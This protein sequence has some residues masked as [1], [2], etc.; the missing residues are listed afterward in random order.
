MGNSLN[1]FSWIASLY[2]SLVKIVFGANLRVAQS[3]L[4]EHIPHGNVL[5][6]GGGSGEFLNLLEEARF[7]GSVVYLDSSSAMIR[8]SAQRTVSFPVEFICGLAEEY[9]SGRI[10]N[11]VVTN[12]FLDVYRDD[13]LQR[14]IETISGQTAYGAIWYVT[15]FTNGGQ[16]HHKVLLWMMYRFFNLTGS[17]DARSL[18]DWNSALGASGWELQRQAKT[19]H[20]FITTCVY[21]K[22]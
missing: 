3:Q 10:Y 7:N 4:I 8:L 20:G 19:D 11:A 13:Q 16:P 22:R 15:D 21:R 2:D 9:Q 1:R 17:I 6:L 14:M 12:F 5:I 18:P